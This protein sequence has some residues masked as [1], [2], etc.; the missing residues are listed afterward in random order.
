MTE[1][2]TEEEKAEL[3][4]LGL[5]NANIYK[6]QESETVL[7]NSVE[8]QIDEATGYA[9]DPETG[10]W[11]DPETGFPIEDAETLYI[12]EGAEIEEETTNE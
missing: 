9:I 8:M 10:A 2:L 5:Y 7:I 4:E 3:Q 6:P 11:V 1:E 12:Q